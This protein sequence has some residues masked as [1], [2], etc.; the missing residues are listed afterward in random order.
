MKH[1]GIYRLLSGVLC[2]SVLFSGNVYS[3]TSADYSDF[4]Q[5][6][7][8]EAMEY[9]LQNNLISGVGNGKIGAKEPLTRAQ[10]A[11][12]LSRVLKTGDADVSVLEDFSDVK[13][14]AWYAPAM[15]NAV[16]QKILF[17]DGEA[18]HPDRPVTRQELFV[19]LARA[20]ALTGGES[21][22]IAAYGDAGSV[23]SWAKDAISAMLAQG[24]AAGYEDKTLRPAQQ[25]TRE[26][27]AQLLYRMR[28]HYDS[29][30]SDTATEEP[31]TETE[32]ETGATEETPKTEQ[33]KTSGGGGGGGS[34]NASSGSAT[35]GVI[36]NAAEAKVQNTLALG[37]WLPLVFEDGYRMGDVTV[38]ADGADVTSALTAVTTDGSIAKLPLTAEPNRV[39]IT[40]GNKT[41]TITLNGSGAPSVYTQSGYLPQYVLTHGAVAAWDYHL[42]N[43]DKDGKVRVSPAKTTFSLAAAANDHPSYS[44]DAELI[45]DESGFNISGN[46]TIMFNYNTQEEK[47]WFDGINQ[48]EL[49]QYNENKYTINANL[50]YTAEKDV[51]HYG[52]KVGE[53]TIPIGQDNFRTNGR[54]YVRVKS[55]A[56]DSALVSIHVVNR[57]APSLQTKETAVSGVNLHFNVKDMVYGITTPIESVMLKDPT[58]ET[59]VLRFIDYYYLFGDLFVLYNDET[60]EDGRNNIPYNGVYTITIRSNGF[61]ECSKSFVVT[62]GK[63]LSSKQAVA[64]YAS[65]YDV[66]T[67]ATG[68]SSGGSGSDGDGGSSMVSADLLFDSDLLVNALLLD[69]LGME[70]TEITKVID[71]W[72]NVICDAVLNKGDTTYY[73]YAGYLDAINDAKVGGAQWLPFAEYLKGNAETTPNRPYALKEVLEDGLLG[74]T[75]NS[76]TYGRLEAPV[77]TV[78]EAKE[79]ADVVLTL[80]D[81]E[82]ANSYMDKVSAL[83]L[84]GDWKELSQ[85]AYEISGN[86]ITIKVGTLKIGENKITV[87]A[88]GY[89]SNVVTIH[90]AKETEKDLSLSVATPISE[91]QDVV[92]T[93]TNSE[94]DFLRNLS[95]VVLK[96]GEG[97]EKTVYH[98]GYEGSTAVY[99]VVSEDGKTITLKNVEPGT[100]TV[101]VS[102]NY[103]ET[104]TTAEFTV[105]RTTALNAAPTVAKHEKQTAG[106]FDRTDFYRL[107]F[108]GMEG[109]DLDAYLSAI[110]KVTVGSAVYEKETGIG[111]EESAYRAKIM[112]DA[113][114][115][116]KDCLDLAANGIDAT[117]GT[118][119][120]VEAKNYEPLT[121]TLKGE[122]TTVTPDPDETEKEKEVPQVAAVA[123]KVKSGF[124]D[125]GRYQFTFKGMSAEDLSSYLQ[126]ITAV[127][128]GQ[129]AYSQSGAFFK[130][131]N[132]TIGRSGFSGYDYL[133]LAD[134]A[135]DKSG[136]TTITIKAE[137]YKDLT[138]EY[139]AANPIK[140]DAPK[141]AEVTKKDDTTYRMTFTGDMSAVELKAY[142]N[143]ITTITVGEE[144]YTAAGYF[145]SKNRYLLADS[146]SSYGSNYDCID[147]YADNGFTAEGDVKIVIQADGYADFTGTF[148]K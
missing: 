15:A 35:T 28:G 125:V 120:T 59:K 114:S 104:M 89:L 109:K 12:I 140:A 132:Y 32:T 7:A 23:S 148:K 95:G 133:D 94:G 48:L 1:K 127:T 110:T 144:S 68:G 83:Y 87:D 82:D 90:Y 49:V 51:D 111:L 26:E 86:T 65:A 62:G 69:A 106:S 92:I 10:L 33:K 39:V 60:A 146:S 24:Y 50:T 134:N 8:K 38:T 85:D 22:D 73:T 30:A 20:F 147:F 119:I 14:D 36:V 75:Q 72:Y 91:G 115:N 16:A 93:V 6:W 46:V 103:Y 108:T 76:D 79:G 136:K 58:G 17:G 135:F 40:G 53:L 137:G 130:A 44:P 54:Y 41:Q 66:V 5:N 37:A 25:V 31:K 145:L 118:T 142:L 13:T 42:T 98:Q 116:F 122:G 45:Q 141:G 47:D 2:T 80:Q 100:Y 97:K 96:D 9:A 126:A 121:Y 3:A 67:H 11:V 18:L 81:T 84:N 57:K 117:N 128:V 78:G 123:Y 105:T 112:N 107:T 29:S 55:A 70:A 131:D 143:A 52:S 101:S 56:G 138:F 61:K 77:F 21:S 88:K 64:T 139:D 4:P 113:S 34:S 74:E 19:I 102:A 71:H 124:D 43:Y 27:F 129:N 63:E 99:Y